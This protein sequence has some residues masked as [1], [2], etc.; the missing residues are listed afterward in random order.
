MSMSGMF[1]RGMYSTNTIF[2]IF[3][4][5]GWICC[6]VEQRKKGVLCRENICL[7]S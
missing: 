2:S 3:F 6:A 7:I 5:G 1:S 4:K